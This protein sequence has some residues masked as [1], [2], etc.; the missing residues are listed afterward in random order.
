MTSSSGQKELQHLERLSYCGETNDAFSK[1]H[2]LRQTCTTVSAPVVS[3]NGPSQL[4][5]W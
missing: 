4:Q 1:F 3:H 2:R 5:T